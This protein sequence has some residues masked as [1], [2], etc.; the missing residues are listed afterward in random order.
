MFWLYCV[1]SKVTAVPIECWEYYCM[2]LL[3]AYIS[4]NENEILL[5]FFNVDLF[6]KN[7]YL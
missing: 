2:V 4:E 6:M 7:Y 5:T 1:R 3:N